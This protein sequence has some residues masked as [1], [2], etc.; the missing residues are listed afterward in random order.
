MRSSLPGCRREDPTRIMVTKSGGVLC[1]PGILEAS[2]RTRPEQEN[3]KGRFHRL[4]NPLELDRNK[5]Y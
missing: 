3:E 5:V 1:L 4:K 2:G